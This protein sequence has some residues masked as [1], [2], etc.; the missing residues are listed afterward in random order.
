MQQRSVN[1]PSRVESDRG[2]GREEEEE[3]QTFLFQYL[4]RRA[5]TD[6]DLPG[7][8]AEVIQHHGQEASARAA[9]AGGDNSAAVNVASMLAD[10]GQSHL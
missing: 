5:Q 9:V 7:K 4:S 2:S 8:D 3:T 1:I 6:K 10:M